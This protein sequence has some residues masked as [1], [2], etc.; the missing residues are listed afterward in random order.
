MSL[1]QQKYDAL[2]A[3]IDNHELAKGLKNTKI[4]DTITALYKADK[5]TSNEFARLMLDLVNYQGYI[6]KVLARSHK[7][8]VQLD[9]PINIDKIDPTVFDD[10]G[11]VGE[12]HNEERAERRE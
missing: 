10:T 4:E 6:L 8:R 9:K 1:T 7:V 12:Y 5:I 2:C 3:I 11:S